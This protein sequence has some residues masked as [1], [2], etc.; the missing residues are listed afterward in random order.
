MRGAAKYAV[1]DMPK[2]HADDKE[3]VWS[4]IRELIGH[5]LRRR[6]EVPKELPLKLLELIRKLDAGEQT[7]RRFAGNLKFGRF[8]ADKVKAVKSA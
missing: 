1:P 2:A 3:L 5:G 7:K 8:I 6:Y 4:C